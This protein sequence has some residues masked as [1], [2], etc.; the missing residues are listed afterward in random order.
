MTDWLS[1]VKRFAKFQ[2]LLINGK[3]DH[4]GHSPKSVDT[5][6]VGK[7]GVLL[8]DEAVINYPGTPQWRLIEVVK[9]SNVE[10]IAKNDPGN[11]QLRDYSKFVDIVTSGKT[12]KPIQ[13]GTTADIH[14]SQST[15][16]M[17]ETRRK[18]DPREPQR[19]C[20]KVSQHCG[21][22]DVSSCDVVEKKPSRGSSELSG[23]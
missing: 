17:I 4:S 2:A 5:I 3:R 10:K 12:Q 23:E 11:P 14:Q 16:C 21:G 19:T 6:I 1:V 8:R 20:T 18:N 15:L 9:S 13:G 7:G 22:K